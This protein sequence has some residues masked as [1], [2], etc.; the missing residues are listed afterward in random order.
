MAQQPGYP[1]PD[2]N[3]PSAEQYEAGPQPGYQDQTTGE[4]APAPAPTTGGRKKR[5]YAGQAYDFGAGANS[6]SGGQYQ[7]SGSI[8]GPQAGGY[9]GYES[10]TQTQPLGFQ[11]AGYGQ[12]YGASQSQARPASYGQPPPAVG[13]Y[14]A[15]DA[16][17]PGSGAPLPQDGMGGITQGMGNMGIGGQVQP[18]PAAP[19]RQVLNQLHPTDLLN[20]PFHVSELDLPP[21]PILLPPNVS[22]FIV[23][24]PISIADSGV[25]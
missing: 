6:A 7:G 24:R 25:I 8:S 18:G 21:P 14:Q 12:E 5:A 11:Q 4:A 23:Y 17:Y 3:Q 16:G 22:T 15:P 13:G 20:Q 2:Y 19:K 10:Q 1:G 9:G